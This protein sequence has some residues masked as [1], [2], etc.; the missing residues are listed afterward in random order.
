MVWAKPK[1]RRGEASGQP[2]SDWFTDVLGHRFGKTR[3]VMALDVQLPGGSHH[4]VEGEFKVPNKLFKLRHIHKGQPWFRAGLR[5]PVTIDDR[6]SGGVTIDWDEFERRGGVA[7][8]YPDEES[9][10]DTV[11]GFVAEVRSQ[12]AAPEPDVPRPDRTTHPPVEGVDFDQWLG[13]VLGVRRR[14]A[15][16]ELE[17]H[18]QA[19]GF[20]AGR[21]D[22]ISAVWY[23]RVQADPAVNAWYLYEQA[24]R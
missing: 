1:A 23:E 18:Y 15:P 21:G 19:S 11:R 3:W 9:V 4:R 16:A 14:M 8:L 7:G 12:P 20:P 17:A 24:D 6:Q 2:E 22:A 13:A 10:A 5:L